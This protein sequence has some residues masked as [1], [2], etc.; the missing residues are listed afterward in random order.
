V[1]K[2]YRKKLI[3]AD[4][5][6]ELQRKCPRCHVDMSLRNYSYDSNIIIDKCPSCQGIWTDK[7]EMQAV[8]R[9][10]KRNPDM[11]G[12]TKALVWSYTE[13]QNPRSKVGRILSVI[14]SLIYMGIAFHLMG[15]R[16]FLIMLCLLP[17]PMFCI[18][19]GE[20]MVAAPWTRFGRIWGLR[21]T[22]PTSGTVLNLVGWILLLVSI[23]SLKYYQFRIEMFE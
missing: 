4:K 8:A 1:K 17:W 2:P 21:I 7:G 9:Y 22:K 16:G 19:L 14:V 23:F 3:N 12:D 10:V 20:D 6:K 11:G 5:A 13:Y 15:S 18:F